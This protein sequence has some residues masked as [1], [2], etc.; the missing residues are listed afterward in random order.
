MGKKNKTA[1][2]QMLV[3]YDNFNLNKVTKI[4]GCGQSCL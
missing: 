4:T 1:K 3:N 2:L